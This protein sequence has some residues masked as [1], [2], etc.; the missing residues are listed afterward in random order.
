MGVQSLQPSRLQAFFS[1]GRPTH[2]MAATRPR[3]SL[4]YLF[5]VGSHP[6]PAHYRGASSVIRIDG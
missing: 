1:S 6:Y 2:D 3:F 5:R 4:A